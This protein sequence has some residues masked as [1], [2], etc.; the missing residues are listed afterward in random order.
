MSLAFYCYKT[1][2]YCE[3]PRYLMIQFFTQ[4]QK[5]TFSDYELKASQKF[6]SFFFLGLVG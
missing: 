5:A 6:I 2:R 4:G 3:L 1:L